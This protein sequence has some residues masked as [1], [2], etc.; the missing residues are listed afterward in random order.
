[1]IESA[2]LDP[3]DNT[4]MRSLGRF[5]YCD[6]EAGCWKQKG[7]SFMDQSSFLPVSFSGVCWRSLS[8]RRHMCGPHWQIRVLLHGWLHRENM[9]GWHRCL[10]HRC[11][12]WLTVLQRSHLRWWWGIQ[13]HMSVSRSPLETLEKNCDSLIN[14]DQVDIFPALPPANPVASASFGHSIVKVPT[15]SLGHLNV[16]PA[17]STSENDLERHPPPPPCSHL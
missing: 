7:C 14:T 6:Q 5:I 4:P 17:Q 8:E 3:G 13:L 15:L 11:L 9:P 12:K 2:V 1:M 16:W 10:Q